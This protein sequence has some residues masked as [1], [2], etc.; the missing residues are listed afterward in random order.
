MKEE[1][2]KSD[3][4]LIADCLS[5]NALAWEVLVER[6][7][8]LVYSIPI[9]YGLGGQDADDIF[10]STWVKLL[11]KLPELRKH[12]KIRSWIITTVVRQCWHVKRKHHH[13]FSFNAY[14]DEE[15]LDFVDSETLVDERMIE[16][17]RRHQME[18]AFSRLPERCKKLLH[19][20]F[21]RE[22]P[23]SYKDISAE[24]GITFTSIAPTR[25]RCLEKLLALYEEEMGDS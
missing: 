4:E 25:S 5:G 8:S 1:S 2:E 17:E 11:E 23:A 15:E 16:I 24:M 7:R 21:F 3:A 14:S 20:L 10:Q 9:K 18:T 19:Y 12:E 13:E 22:P 6:Y